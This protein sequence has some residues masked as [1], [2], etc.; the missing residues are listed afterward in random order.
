MAEAFG[1]QPL[2]RVLNELGLKNSD[3][4]GASKEQLTHKQVSKARAGKPVT[5]NIQT[6]VMNALNALS[7]EKQYNFTDLFSYRGK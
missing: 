4:V 5:H 6:K 7:K 2:D 3:L 1:G